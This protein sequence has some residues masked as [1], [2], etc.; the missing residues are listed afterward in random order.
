MPGTYSKLLYHTVFSTKQRAAWLKPALASRIYEYLGGI[1]RGEGGVAHQINGMPDHVHLLIGWRTDESI[2]VLM[3]NLKAHSSRWIHETFPGCTGFRWQEGY[4]VFTV[5]RSQFEA[6]DAYIGNQEQHHY[7]R[8]FD[9]ELRELLRVHDI[10]YD[11]RYLL[12]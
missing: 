5:S 9:E 6:V 1:V 12:D 11:E 4:S 10:A 8:S 2:S 7:G 3:R